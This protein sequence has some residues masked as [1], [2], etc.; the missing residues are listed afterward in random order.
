MNAVMQV[1]GGMVVA[2]PWLIL[3]DRNPD[4]LYRLTD[5]LGGFVDSS[6]IKEKSSGA[7]VIELLNR[8]QFSRLAAWLRIPCPVSKVVEWTNTD[9]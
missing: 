7:L 4:D 5:R 8:E 1:T 2:G 3:T 6:E 9:M